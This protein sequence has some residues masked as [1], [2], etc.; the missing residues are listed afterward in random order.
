[1]LKTSAVRRLGKLRI[2]KE[3]LK[4]FPKPSRMGQPVPTQWEKSSIFQRD[5]N[6]SKQIAKN[7]Y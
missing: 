4:F 7:S 1:M 3:I 2:D 5:P 6:K